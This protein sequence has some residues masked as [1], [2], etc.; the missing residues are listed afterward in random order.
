MKKA[1]GEMILVGLILTVLAWQASQATWQAHLQ[2]DVVT[3]QQRA[4][5]FL[6]NF[7]WAGLSG[8]E[9]Q[10]GALWF[11]VGVGWLVARS[12]VFEMYRMGVIAVNLALLAGHYWLI[13]KWGGK[14]AGV[15]F[16]WLALMVGPIL[17]YRFELLVSGLVLIAWRLMQKQRSGAAAFWLGLATAVKVYPIVLLPVG[18]MELGREKKWG[19]MIRAGGMFGLGIWLPIGAWFLAGGEWESF[20]TALKFHGLKPVGLEGVWASL[21]LPWHMVT[22]VPLALTPGYGVHG[23]TPFGVEIW[24]R[25]LDWVWLP[26]VGLLWWRLRRKRNEEVE[27][28]TPFVLLAIFVFLAKVMNPQY[29]WW[30]VVFWPL[31]EWKESRRDE[32]WLIGGSLGV[33]LLLTQIMYPIFY[34]DYLNWFPEMAGVSP[35]LVVMESRNVMLATVI[36]WA[37]YR[38]WQRRAT[39]LIAE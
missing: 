21:L 19:E 37:V 7:S 35:L 36:G 20:W 14:K 16:G 28:L 13:R 18:L 6:D 24:R 2:V 33:G 26:P 10:P 3:F 27:W 38:W 5:Y 34:T 30:F 29:L 9:Y 4:M 8:N 1:L 15:M 39:V 32:W 25:V 23:F 12:E 22:G 17:L 11:F 31:V